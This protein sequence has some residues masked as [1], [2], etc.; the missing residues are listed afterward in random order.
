MTMPEMSP[1][2]RALYVI[3]IAAELA[4]VHPQTLRIYERKGLLDPSRTGGG[5]RRYSDADIAQMQRI[6]ELTNAGVN[7]EGVRRILAL[8]AE[9]SRLE[10]DLAESRSEASARVAETHRHYRRDLVPLRAEIVPMNIR[11]APLRRQ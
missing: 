1:S 2:T 7:L 4:G 6:L 11:K 10:D 8:E 9:V 3:S 5:A